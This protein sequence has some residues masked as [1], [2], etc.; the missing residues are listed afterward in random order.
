VIRIDEPAEPMAEPVPA[1]P[2]EVPASRGEVGAEDEGEHDEAEYDEGEYEDDEYED[3]EY[4][5]EDGEDYVIDKT[6]AAL[7]EEAWE[8]EDAEITILARKKLAKQPPERKADE[9]EAEA[10]RKKRRRRRRKASRVPPREAFS[11]P[12]LVKESGGESAPRS[13]RGSRRKSASPPLVEYVRGPLRINMTPIASA[14]PNDQPPSPRG[15]KRRKRR[16]PNGQSPAPTA[17]SPAHGSPTPRS[18]PGDGAPAAPGSDKKR[19]RRRRRRKGGGGAEADGPVVTFFST[20]GSSNG[21]KKRRRRRRRRPGA[22]DSSNPPGS[23]N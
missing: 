23:D 9:V 12:V 4:E 19:R 2:L 6:A 16:L 22:G 5:D 8:P 11:S 1:A 3:D 10:P 21:K 13:R 15:K 14:T 17:A 7:A 20:E 18:E